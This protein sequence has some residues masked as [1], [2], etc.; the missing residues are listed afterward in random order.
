MG[1]SSE[2]CPQCGHPVPA[3]NTMSVPAMPDDAYRGWPLRTT[4]YQRLICPECG[5]RGERPVFI[6]RTRWEQSAKLRD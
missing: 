1:K 5:Q 4:R 6:G 2:L 3:V